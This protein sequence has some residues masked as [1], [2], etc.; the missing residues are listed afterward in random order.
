MHN[1]A[2]LC[3]PTPRPHRR[4]EPGRGHCAKTFLGAWRHGPELLENKRPVP[5]WLIHVVRHLLI[6][7][8][9]ATR[10]RPVPADVDYHP[11]PAVDGGPDQLLDQTILLDAVQ[12][13]SATRLDRLRLQ[14]RLLAGFPFVVNV[15]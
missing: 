12:R 13:L 14:H 8:A 4:S 5:A 6:D 2:R 9:R 3:S 1:T 7:A 15:G 10:A 11:E